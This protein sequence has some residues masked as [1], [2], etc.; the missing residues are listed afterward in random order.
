[1]KFELILPKKILVFSRYAA[2]I[3]SLIFLIANTAN[4]GRIGSCGKLRS[5]LL[6]FQTGGDDLRGDSE[7]VIWLMT[8]SGDVELQHVWG[9][10]G[11]DSTN[12]RVVAL[13]NPN[14]DVDS[15]SVTGVKMRMISH[16]L[17]PEADD[18]WIMDGFMLNG[19]SG[20]GKYKYTLSANGNPVKHFNGS[21]PW[22][23]KN[24]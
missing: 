17:W 14:W 10:F 15:C 6:N 5:F 1:M 23:Q 3:V 8:T 9:R 13:Q 12:S 18:N 21:S 24:E 20:T 22:W 7:L 11:N 4:A 2:F 19:Y 16:P